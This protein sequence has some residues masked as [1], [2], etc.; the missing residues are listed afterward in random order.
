M[1]RLCVYVLQSTWKLAVVVYLKCCPGFTDE[2]YGK[3]SR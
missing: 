3:R 1:G 2:N